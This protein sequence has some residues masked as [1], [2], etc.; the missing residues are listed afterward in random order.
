MLVYSKNILGDWFIL[1]GKRKG[2]CFSGRV[3]STSKNS[4]WT[5]GQFSDYWSINN[6]R[7]LCKTEKTNLFANGY[8]SPMK[9]G[10]DFDNTLFTTNAYLF[11]EVGKQTIFNKLV[12]L[13]V[14]YK[15]KKGWIIIL[16]TLREKGKGLEEALEICRKYNIPIDLVNENY[17]DDVE[18][19]GDSRKI[20]CNLSI[21]DT[22]VG[23]IGF[24]LRHCK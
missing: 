5:L 17:P 8:Y 19:W 6:L 21:D 24:L 18:F 10:V 16:N 20:G 9:L 11:P 15:K 22:Q 13:F 1:D 12:S 4:P 7:K 2:K 23:L 14:R 3:I